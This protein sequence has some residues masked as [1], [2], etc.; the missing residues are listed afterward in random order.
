M[1]S[2]N[3]KP[4]VKLACLYLLWKGFQTVFDV[5]PRHWSLHII[6]FLFTQKSLPA[7]MVD[8]GRLS[9]FTRQ[10]SALLKKHN[11]SVKFGYFDCSGGS[12]NLNGRKRRQIN[13]QSSGKTAEERGC[14]RNKV[15][16]KT[17][18]FVIMQIGNVLHSGRS[19][20]TAS[21]L[22]TCVP[23]CHWVQLMEYNEWYNEEQIRKTTHT[24]KIPRI[25]IECD[26]YTSTRHQWYQWGPVQSPKDTKSICRR[27]T[28]LQSSLFPQIFIM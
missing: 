28:R 7:F 21:S 12:A 18:L 4:L 3:K 26:W 19:S 22:V 2:T 6:W 17:A 23:S 27:T 1:Q 9:F 15:I 25:H 8:G 10:L 20:Y 13:S 16:M 5:A 14:V 11:K 24:H